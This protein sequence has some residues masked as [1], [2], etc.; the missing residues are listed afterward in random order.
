M[1]RARSLGALAAA[2]VLLVGCGGEEGSVA[3]APEATVGDTTSPSPTEEP[4]ETVAAASGKVMAVERAHARAPEGWSV[5]R[6]LPGVLDSWVANERGTVNQVYLSDLGTVSSDSLR[7]L[8]RTGGLK[9]FSGRPE[10]SYDA[11]LAG[12]DAFRATGDG[13]LGPREEYGA[14]RGGAA[15]VLAFEF[16]ASMPASRRRE[17]VDQVMASFRWS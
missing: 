14:L 8:V 5:K 4:G 6:Q 16:S 2:L 10:V 11:E 17:V 3:D 9:N 7:Q 15:V 12:E 1:K 13:V